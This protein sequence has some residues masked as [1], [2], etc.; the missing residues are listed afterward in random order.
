MTDKNAKIR[1]LT[2]LLAD[3]PATAPVAERLALER[4]L[5]RLTA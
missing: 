1:T 5:A 3:L 4:E 2:A